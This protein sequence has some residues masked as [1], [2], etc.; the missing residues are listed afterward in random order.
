MKIVPNKDGI[1]TL[2]CPNGYTFTGTYKEC[3]N[4]V[5]ELFQK[6]SRKDESRKQRI[7]RDFFLR[8]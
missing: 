6:G 4:V 7:V 2:V 1:H 8:T 3:Q 5:S